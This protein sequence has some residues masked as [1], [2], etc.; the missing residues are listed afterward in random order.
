MRTFAHMI[1]HKKR[2]DRHITLHYQT[3]FFRLCRFLRQLT[4]RNIPLR[5]RSK[6]F[7]RQSYRFLKRYIPRDSKHCIIGRIKT[8]KEIFYFIQRGIGYVRQFFADSRP[9]IR[10]HLVS[11]RAQQMA[12]VAIRLIET[13][14]FELFHY[15]PPLH[16]QTPFIEIKTQHTV[17]LQPESNLHILPGNGQIIIR[18]IVIC[19]GIILATGQLERSIVIGDIHGASKHQ[20]LKKMSK[21]RMI[22]VFVPG[23]H[24]IYYIKSHHLRAFI[25]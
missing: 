20:M 7:L 15:H 21:A 18:N 2:I 9:L 24:I 5:D 3:A 16:I 12:H 14:L 22:G 23:P 1:S 8:E 17:R 13:T 6:P 19:P 4:Y 25:L 10:M 11:K